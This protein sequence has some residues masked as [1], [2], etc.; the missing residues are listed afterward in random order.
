[1][2]RWLALL[3]VV[4]FSGC[5]SPTSPDLPL[6]LDLGSLTERQRFIY[7]YT[8]CLGEW[9][10]IGE[11]RVTFEYDLGDSAAGKAVTAH[12]WVRYHIESVENGPD[13][14]LKALAAHEVSHLT[15]ANEVQAVELENVWPQICGC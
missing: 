5:N 10:G 14:Y 3:A 11:I 7:N 2:K 4:V 13:S 12:R 8:Q 1:M 9:T 15:G 6:G